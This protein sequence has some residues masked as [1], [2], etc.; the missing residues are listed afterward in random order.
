[1]PCKQTLSRFQHWQEMIAEPPLQSIDHPLLIEKE[2][3]LKVL[4]T[5]LVHSIISGNKAYKLKYN[6]EAALQ[7]RA[8]GVLSFGGAWSNHLHALAYSCYQLNLP[9]VAVIRGEPEL[10]LKSAMLQDLKQWDCQLHFVTRK[11]YRLRDDPEW[12]QS[13]AETFPDYFM[14]PEGGSSPL[15]APGVA[16]LAIQLEQRCKEADWQ[17]DQIWCA[18]GTGGTLAGLIAGR[19]Q[20][21]QLIGVPVLKGADF[22]RQE[23]ADRL[24]SGSSVEDRAQGQQNWSLLLD[25]HGGGYGKV[26]NTLLEQMAYLEECLSGDTFPLSLDPIYTGKLFCRFWQAVEQGDIPKGSRVILIHTGGLQGRRGFGFD[27]QLPV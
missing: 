7:Q 12:L 19:T 11:A 2:I 27:W 20:D 3:E 6:L 17:P 5:D 9:C 24:T 26:S 13:L 21:Y 8:R 14:V 10:I 25:G 23:I 4:R 22:L 16:E 18:V 15:A 1:M